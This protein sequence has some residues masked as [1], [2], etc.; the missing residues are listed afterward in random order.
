MEEVQPE[1]DDEDVE[2]ARIAEAAAKANET[3]KKSKKEARPVGSTIS[4]VQWRKSR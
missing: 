1:V 2:A 3:A 4:H